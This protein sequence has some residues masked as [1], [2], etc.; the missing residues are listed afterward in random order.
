MTDLLGEYHWEVEPRQIYI[1]VEPVRNCG[2][3][4]MH[5]FNLPESQTVKPVDFGDIPSFVIFHQLPVSDVF[6]ILRKLT[7]SSR[8]ISSASSGDSLGVVV[9]T[10]GSAS[11]SRCIRSLCWPRLR[12]LQLA[13]A[14][15]LDAYLLGVN[16]LMVEPP[17][18]TG[19]PGPRTFHIV[20]V[21]CELRRSVLYEMGR[22]II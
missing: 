7:S 3:P 10:D 2:L 8:P 15:H 22:V 13:D 19:L 1:Q 18:G 17:T 5:L 14:Y 9:C 6:C 20:N 11:L 16:R 12:V 21:N 4:L